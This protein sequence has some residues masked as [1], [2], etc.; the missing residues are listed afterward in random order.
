M[1]NY[2]G[3]SGFP[4]ATEGCC[5]RYCEIYFIN[6]AGQTLTRMSM[7]DRPSG[8]TGFL[9][10]QQLNK[11]RILET[12]ALRRFISSAEKRHTIC[13]VCEANSLVFFS[14]AILAAE[15]KPSALAPFLRNIPAME[16]GGYNS[17]EFK[18][19]RSQFCT[20]MYENCQC[21]PFNP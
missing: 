21:C 6:L 11:M 10:M 4:S 20:R 2:L 19:T 13:D 7:F 5:I 3:R 18:K 14:R 1:D 8:F 16:G 15:N 17:F 12:V 9:K